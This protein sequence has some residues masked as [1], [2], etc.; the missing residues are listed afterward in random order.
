MNRPLV[1]TLLAMV[2]SVAA[3]V[4]TPEVDAAPR[5]GCTSDPAARAPSAAASRKLVIAA[6]V[7]ADPASCAAVPEAR[8]LR[9]HHGSLKVLPTCTAVAQT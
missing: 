5:V 9:W 3:A 7:G 1:M 8:Y 6:D 2:A 4:A